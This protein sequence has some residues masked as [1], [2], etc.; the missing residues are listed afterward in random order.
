MS[1]D[2]FTKTVIIEVRDPYQSRAYYYKTSLSLFY[3]KVVASHLPH[4]SIRYKWCKEKISDRDR[5]PSTN[6]YW[7]YSQ[8]SFEWCCCSVCWRSERRPLR[9]CS[10]VLYK[11]NSY[12]SLFVSFVSFWRSKQHYDAEGNTYSFLGKTH[13]APMR[14]IYFILFHLD[15]I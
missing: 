9:L 15:A 1:R 12:P 6:R 4:C 2:W 8:S 7:Y 13:M 10:W 11:T 14:S 5:N 3:N